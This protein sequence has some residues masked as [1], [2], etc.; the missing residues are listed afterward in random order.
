MG[1]SEAR[2]ISDGA[3]APLSPSVVACM[4]RLKWRRWKSTICSLALNKLEPEI[5]FLLCEDSIIS[6]SSKLHFWKSSLLM[7]TIWTANLKGYDKYVVIWPGV[8]SRAALWSCNPCR[9][10]FMK[11]PHQSACCYP[12]E[13]IV[14]A[15]GDCGDCFKSFPLKRL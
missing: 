12:S 6:S 1:W 5:H 2:Q 8:N 10:N 11:Q 15:A 9:T 13:W 7:L 14:T 3:I 4:V